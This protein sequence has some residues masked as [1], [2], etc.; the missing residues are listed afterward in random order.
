MRLLSGLIVMLAMAPDDAARS[1]RSAVG[2][3]TAPRLCRS[4]GMPRAGHLGWSGV[5]GIDPEEQDDLDPGP[6]GAD[7]PAEGG[8]L[9]PLAPPLQ[10]A[11]SPRTPAAP[12]SDAPRLNRLRC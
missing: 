12:P 5:L 8:S 4:A 10:P 11:S 2:G 3:A 1:R 7:L 9:W 6:I